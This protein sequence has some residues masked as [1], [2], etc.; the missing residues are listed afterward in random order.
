MNIEFQYIG[1]YFVKQFMHI[2]TAQCYKSRKHKNTGKNCSF[3]YL[4]QYLWWQQ[5]CH[6]TT[7]R[8]EA[9]GSGV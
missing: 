6:A 8:V 4:W 3:R 5:A 1:S 7:R 9:G 2:I